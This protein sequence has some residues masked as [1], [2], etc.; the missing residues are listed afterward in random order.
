MMIFHSHLL[1]RTH[2]WNASFWKRRKQNLMQIWMWSI[3]KGKF[4]GDQKEWKR[5]GENKS[6]YCHHN[7]EPNTGIKVRFINEE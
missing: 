3:E 6:G 5:P 4:Q 2:Q 7:E 1:Q